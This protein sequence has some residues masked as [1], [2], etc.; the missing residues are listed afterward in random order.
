MAL[1]CEDFTFHASFFSSMVIHDLVRHGKTGSISGHLPLMLTLI[2]R[3]FCVATRPPRAGLSHR[4]VRAR[5][6][7]SREGP[8]SGTVPPY[9]RRE[10]T[11]STHLPAR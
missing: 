4:C 3:S 5:R 8:L 11:G 9:S 1:L 6:S 10:E 2:H 7:R